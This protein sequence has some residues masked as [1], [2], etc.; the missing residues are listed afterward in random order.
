[1]AYF[2]G[3]GSRRKLESVHPDLIRVVE[4]AIEI[5]KQDFSVCDGL[6]SLVQQK[7]Y[8][9]TGASHTLRSKHLRQ[10]DGFSHAVDLVPYINGQIRW[11]WE[12]I[13]R[14]AKAIRYAAN[15][16]DVRLRWGGHWGLLT[17]TSVDPEKLVATYVARKKREG[18][19]AF[20]D[21]P[22]YELK[23]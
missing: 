6:R 18:S 14:I 2:L 7:E 17:G 20:I 19:K 1:M 15:E 9:R 13:Y 21:G 8:V 10:P 11:E 4:R 12:P 5:T 22:H 16:L 23:S 3:K